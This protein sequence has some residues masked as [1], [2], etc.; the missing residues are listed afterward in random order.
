MNWKFWRRRPTD[1]EEIE[2]YDD[3]SIRF[4]VHRDGSFH[5]DVGLPSSEDDNERAELISQFAMLLHT[6][7]CGAMELHINRA[8]ILAGEEEGL[9]NEAYFVLHTLKSFDSE[10]HPKGGP[11]V[12]PLDAFR[13]TRGMNDD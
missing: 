2:G 10:S 13:P 6:V 9:K 12:T 8:I 1:D 7:Q 5:I 3:P 4:E 11:V